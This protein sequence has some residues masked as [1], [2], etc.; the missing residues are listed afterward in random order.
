MNF[1]PVRRARGALAAFARQGHLAARGLAVADSR[2]LVRALFLSSA[3]AEDV[4]PY[5]GAGRTLDQL[6][7]HTGCRRPERLGAWLAV[8]T[9]LGEL[10][11]RGDRFVVAGRRARALAAGDELLTAH[12]RSMLEY[13][14][15]PYVELGRRLRDDPGVGRDDLDRYADDIARVSL[16]AAPFI[17]PLVHRTVAGLAPARVLDVGCG[18]GA[19][20]RAALEA[21]PAVVV[22]GID[23][24]QDVVQSA[25]RS[26]D[27]AGLG[28]RARLHVG[29]VRE[30][31]STS[32]S[33]FDLVLLLNNIYYFDRGD[34]V[35]LY[36]ALGDALTER[37]QL[38]VV[39]M[40]SPGSIAATHLDFMLRCQ[41]GAASLPGRGEL[42]TDLIEAGLGLSEE[43]RLVPTEPFFA[44]RAARRSA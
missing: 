9:D 33:R 26:L 29:D 30:W 5:L 13:Q 43:R 23:L 20:A 18:N 21:D 14:V 44:V 24:A 11:R 17:A 25:R 10:R 35:E 37:G 15:G 28:A 12:Y 42:S 4:L 8:G 19:Y 31:L 32:E 7:A 22:D 34:R 40:T 16:A 27:A 6:A 2:A 39:S 3:V 36:R 41:A 1:H 38:L